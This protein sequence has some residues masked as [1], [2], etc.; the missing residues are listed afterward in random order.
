MD[1]ATKKYTLWLSGTEGHWLNFLSVI[2]STKFW[3][4]DARSSDGIPA[5]CVHIRSPGLCQN[6]LATALPHGNGCARLRGIG[7]DR[8]E[9]R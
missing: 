7:G 8:F 2:H 1:K 3:K 5:S 4:T 9:R 6:D